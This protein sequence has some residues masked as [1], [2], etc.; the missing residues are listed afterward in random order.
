MEKIILKTEAVYLK[1]KELTGA[2]LMKKNNQLVYVRNLGNY[3]SQ[4][5]F[6]NS[7]TYF[8]EKHEMENFEE[9]DASEFLE[10]FNESFIVINS[11][12]CN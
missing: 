4:I 7:D 10:A 12:I 1:G 11:K 3:K 2:Y 9:C 8:G 5:E 6:L